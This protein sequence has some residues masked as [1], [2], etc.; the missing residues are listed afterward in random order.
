MN[1]GETLMKLTK[2]SIL[3]IA[4]LVCAFVFGSTE[5]F[6][7]PT[8]AATKVDTKK[9]QTAT[10]PVAK[11]N[12]S[13]V[14]EIAVGNYADLVTETVERNFVDRQVVLPEAPTF[15]TTHVPRV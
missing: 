4:L 2:F 8:P 6:A 5:S 14:K 9:Q 3:A 11:S 15:D 1:G 13:I 10:V 7:A 12:D